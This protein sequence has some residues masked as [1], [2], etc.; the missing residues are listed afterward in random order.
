MQN[1]SPP[2][3]PRWHHR[4]TSSR[5]LAAVIVLLVTVATLVFLAP[6]LAFDDEGAT[7]SAVIFALAQ[8]EKLD[9]DFRPFDSK[10]DRFLQGRARLAPAELRRPRSTISKHS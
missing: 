4:K 3:A 5:R 6:A 7:L 1:D 8:Y 9:P 2:A 10:Y